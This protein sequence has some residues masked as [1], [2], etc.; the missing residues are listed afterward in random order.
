[1]GSGLGKTDE[2]TI[3]SSGCRSKKNKNSCE[4]NTSLTLI[5]VLQLF[6]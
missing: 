1:M 2:T 3:L 4:R 5:Y 6:Y